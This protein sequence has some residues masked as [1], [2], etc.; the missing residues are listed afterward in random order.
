MSLP[1][2]V[3]P[4]C[5]I[6]WPHWENKSLFSVGTSEVLLQRVVTGSGIAQMVTCSLLLGEVFWG[7]AYSDVTAGFRPAVKSPRMSCLTFVIK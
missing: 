3:C 1:V 6:S 7:A 2:S 4:Q 5:V